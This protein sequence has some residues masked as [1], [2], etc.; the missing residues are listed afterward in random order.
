MTPDPVTVAVVAAAG[1]TAVG[2]SVA[3]WYYVR[4]IGIEK[5][6]SAD[7]NANNRRLI[8]VEQG[9]AETQRR[10][11]EEMLAIERAKL[12]ARRGDGA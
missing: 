1:F 9:K 8:E 7:M 11:Y 12:E 10:Y 6:R 5:Q 3:A 4:R 2:S